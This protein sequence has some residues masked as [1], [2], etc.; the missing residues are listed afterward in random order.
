[1]GVPTTAHFIYIP[2]VLII[3]IVIGWILGARAQK[4]QAAAAEEREKQ[5]AARRAAR[6]GENDKQPP[7]SS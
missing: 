2:F 4:D 3:G 6:R 5:K 7:P 1:M